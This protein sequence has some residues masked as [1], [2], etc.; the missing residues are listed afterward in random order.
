MSDTAAFVVL[1]PARLGSSRLPDKPLADIAGLPMVIRVAQQALKS[2]AQR[3]VVAADHERILAA[4]REHGIE[5]ILTRSDHPSG[6]DRLAEAVSLLGLSPD[7]IVVNVQGDE[8]LIDPRHIEQVAGTLADSPNTSIS[9]LAHPI[10]E[11]KE[12]Q[13]PHVVKVVLDK[14]SNASYFSRASI[15]CWRDAV[16]DQLPPFLVYRHVGLYAYRAAFLSLFPTLSVA[17]TEQSEA[18]EQLRAIWHG[19]RIAVHVSN[20]ASAPGVD[21]PEDLIRVNQLFKT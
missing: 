1:I 10:T 15:P 4:S 12:W 19:H 13:S 14:Q 17:P 20:S 11:W 21:T 16:P 7:T 8:P 2:A 3:V 9:T 5:A 6:S 18:L